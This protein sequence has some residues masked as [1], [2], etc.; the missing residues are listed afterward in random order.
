MDVCMREENEAA[1]SRFAFVGDGLYCGDGGLELQRLWL[2]AD[3]C[4]ENRPFLDETCKKR[5]L[6]L[7]RVQELVI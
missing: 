2:D 1:A 6:L 5:M 7:V 4:C 3:F